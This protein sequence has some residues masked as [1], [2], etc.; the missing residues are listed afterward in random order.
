MMSSSSS[1]WLGKLFKKTPKYSLPDLPGLKL[2]QNLRI[3]GVYKKGEFIG[4]KYEVYGVLGKGGFGV[5]YL[6]FSKETKEV[7]ALKTFRDE[8]VTDQEILTRF[9]KEASVWVELGDHPNLVRANFIDTI[10]DRIFIGMEYVAPNH[11][12]LNTLEDYLHRQPPDLAQ[13][14]RWAIQICHGMEYAYSKGVRAHRDLK[15]AN[16]M[17]TEEKTAKVTD[18]GLAGV[19]R[20][21]SVLRSID[22]NTQPGKNVYSGQTMLGT[23]FGTPTHMPP[24]QFENAAGCDERSDIYSFGIVLYQMATGGRLPF[25]APL[26]RNGSDHETA[27]FWQAMR[28]LHRE[29]PLPGLDFPLFN[30]IEHCLEKQPRERYKTF[31]ELRPDLELL[32]QNLTGEKI[33]TPRPVS[34][35][36]WIWSN[37]GNSLNN[38][39]RYK[40]AITCLDKALALDPRD[41]FAWNN[42]GN[43]LNSL[44]RPEEALQ[45]YDRAIK[46]DSRYLNPWFNKGVIFDTLGRPEE[47]IGCLEKVLEIDPQFI[48]GWYNKGNAYNHLN[49]IEEAIPCFEKAIELDKNYI[50]AWNNKGVSLFD[51]GRYEEV[52]LCCDR[53]LELDPQYVHAW[54]NK[55]NSLGCLGRHEEALIYLDKALELDPRYFFAWNNKGFSLYCLGRYEEAITCCEKA[56]KINKLYVD[57]WNTKALAEDKLGKWWKSVESFTWF[58]KLA[59]AKYS[60]E[61][62]YAQKRVDE[63]CGR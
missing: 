2:K 45:C 25:L 51:L 7:L 1:N 31:K 18:F 63:M 47:A 49:R 53:V 12:G 26:P 35:N 21:S 62:E 24:E 22:S 14:L 54:N 27:A 32:L 43:S 56:L 23:G 29:S 10:S 38:L 40:E 30:I 6:V 37:K 28:Q 41:E 48:F 16:I 8:F 17:I 58:L 46:I 39:G 44:G 61:I 60:K 19:M 5:V 4:Q 20:G 34:Y 59:P 50:D 15:P 42:K 33:P 3:E 9:Y 57:A 13:S 52:I 11:E 36:A 55:G